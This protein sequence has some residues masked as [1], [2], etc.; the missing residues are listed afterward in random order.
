MTEGIGFYCGIAMRWFRDAFC[1]LER[2]EAARRGR[3]RL[4]RAWRRRPRRSRPGP[5]GVVGDLL[6]P[7]GRQALGPGVARR[8]SASTSTDPAASGRTACI[9]AIEEQA[10]YAARGHLAIVEELTGADVDERRLHRRRGQGHA[11]AADR[12]RRARACRCTC[13]W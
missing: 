1:E 7:H 2:R 10:A 8:S 6:E 9:R 13:R 5:N 3:R 4:R 12:R 11:V